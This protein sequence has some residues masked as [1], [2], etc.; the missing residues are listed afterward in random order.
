VPV[1][2]KA[3]LT[4]LWSGQSNAQSIEI[5]QTLALLTVPYEPNMGRL[6]VHPSRTDTCVQKAEV[7][8]DKRYDA[9]PL[10]GPGKLDDPGTILS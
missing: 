6:H 10:Q 2:V 5:V 3:P 7:N 8:I 4:H 9:E 1:F